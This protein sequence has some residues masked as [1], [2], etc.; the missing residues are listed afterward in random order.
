MAHFAE[1]DENNIVKRV[2]VVNNEVLLDENN[3]EQEHL[4]IEF[5][6]NLFSGNWIQ[7]SYNS[8]FRKEFAGIGFIYDAEN[9][10]FQRPKIEQIN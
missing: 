3:V 4:G 2:I 9:D 5:C 7:T 8:K 10:C 1:I 6:K